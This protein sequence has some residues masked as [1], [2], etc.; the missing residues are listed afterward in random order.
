[1][2][3]EYFLRQAG[4]NAS[5]RQIPRHAAPWLVALAHQLASWT[6][7]PDWDPEWDLAAVRKPFQEVAALV[8]EGSLRDLG[9]STAPAILALIAPYQVVGGCEAK[10]LG[11]A[12]KGL[13][14][15]H[16]PGFCNKV[17]DT[18]QQHGLIARDPAEERA[19]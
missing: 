16:L 15:R 18:W 7:R 2:A 1:V 13:V 8:A 6:V 17:L 4:I 9:R 11:T 19:C 10:N 5:D 14:R 3:A 12:C